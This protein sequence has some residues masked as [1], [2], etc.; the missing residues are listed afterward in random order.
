[1]PARAAAVRA[2][3]GDDG[4]RRLRAAAGRVGGGGEPVRAARSGRARA[5][6]HPGQG[7]SGDPGSRGAGR[8]LVRGREHARRPDV[9]GARPEDAGAM[10]GSITRG[11]GFWLACG[12]LG[13]LGLVALGV[14]V[15]PLPAPDTP[16]GAPNL[17]PFSAFPE[18]LGTDGIGRSVLSR[19]AHGARI[20]LTVSLGAT[21][22]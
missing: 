12:W 22:V 15:L 20:S 11:A 5:A 18:V 19:L 14:G 3:A 7:H 6:V 10:S 4:G 2:A 13:L 8:H 21:L 16:V 1:V 9:H 17:P